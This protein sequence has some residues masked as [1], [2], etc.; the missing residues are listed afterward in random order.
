M[1]DS[2]LIKISKFLSKYL[3][4][5]PQ[6]I[7]LKLAP[8]GW[9]AIDELLTACAK[10]KFPVSRQELQLV[11]EFNDKQRFSFDSTD[12]LIRANQGHTVEVD[13]Q[14]ES[15]VP[16]DVLYHGTGKKSVESILQTGLSKMSRHHVHLS[17]DIATAHRVG[18]RHGKPVVLAVDSCAMYQ[19][20]YIFYCSDN[21]VWLVDHVP[22][23]YLRQIQTIPYG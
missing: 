23:E 4:H 9:V 12:T 2:R 5:T 7:G 17:K 22:P 10:N 14:L 3:R 13:L 11:V 20:G 15:A 6:D 16:P 8:G 1:N 21:G 18:A 19:A